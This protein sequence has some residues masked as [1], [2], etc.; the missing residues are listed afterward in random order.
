[1]PV[2]PEDFIGS[3]VRT[4]RFQ[5]GMVLHFDTKS[6]HVHENSLHYYENNLNTFCEMM[7][8]GEVQIVWEDLNL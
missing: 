6:R 5:L 1:M 7:E 2:F 3:S 4:V 8:V